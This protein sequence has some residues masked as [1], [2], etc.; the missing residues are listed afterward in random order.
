VNKLVASIVEGTAFY[1][2]YLAPGAA[3]Q[4]DVLRPRMTKDFE[5]Y[6]VDPAAFGPDEYYL[7]FDNG[8]VALVHLPHEERRGN[9]G[10]DVYPADAYPANAPATRSRDQR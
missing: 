4:L 10:F 2:P 6:R 5:L 1:E 3:A 9:V 8:A 7:R